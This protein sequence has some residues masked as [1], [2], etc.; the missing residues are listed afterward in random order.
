M[1]EQEVLKKLG[2]TSETEEELE[3]ARKDLNSVE[4]L[5]HYELKYAEKDE[6][7]YKLTD[8]VKQKPDMIIK[9]FS[10]H[11]QLILP[12]FY[13]AY[14]RIIITGWR[15]CLD[16]NM[17]YYHKGVR[18]DESWIKRRYK[19]QVDLNH[20]DA[21]CIDWLMNQLLFEKKHGDISKHYHM[22]AG[23]IFG[24][25]TN[26]TPLISDFLGSDQNYNHINIY[27]QFKSA[28]ENNKKNGQDYGQSHFENEARD[29]KPCYYEAEAIFR[30]W[31]DVV[32][33]GTRIR[34]IDI[35][36][37]E[38]L[39]HVFIPNVAHGDFPKDSI[40]NNDATAVNYR[41]FFK[42]GDLRPL[43]WKD[44]DFQK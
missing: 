9:T 32:P 26:L 44:I 27:P 39:R 29:N 15:A 14:G 28:N 18:H 25:F 24:R 11:H 1:D 19:E 23:H 6:N 30:D 43:K 13:Y 33:I 10:A 35:S 4:Q 16:K 36:N 7:Y 2:F 12:V 17:G 34:I 38:E 22:D 3:Q 41:N 8:K 20:T 21:D 5:K 37:S 42:E 31:N 40:L